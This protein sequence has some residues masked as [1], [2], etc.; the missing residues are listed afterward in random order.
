MKQAVSVIVAVALIMTIAAPAFAQDESDYLHFPYR[1]A[2]FIDGGIGVP[3]QPEGFN[4]LWNAALPFT[5]GVNVVVMDYVH[6][7]GAFTYATWGLSEIPTKRK[8][9]ITGTN[10]IEGGGIT[11]TVLSVSA[12]INA[13]PKKRANPFLQV[14]VGIYSA[15]ADDLQVLDS[16][17]NSPTALQPFELSMEDASGV[18][19]S[20][21]LGLESSLNETWNAYTRLV[22]NFGLGGDFKPR[23]LVERN[24]NVE[25]DGGSL[26][27]GALVVGIALK[28]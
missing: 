11:T 18:V 10:P 8:L 9:K 5:V 12:K 22:W 19:I 4:D 25:I 27:F 23:A 16:G 2:I 17:S 15:S 7:Q 1:V 14:G 26:S 20:W 3:S 6:L 13:T 21:G 28:L 24:T